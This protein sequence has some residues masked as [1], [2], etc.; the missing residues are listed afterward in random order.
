[1][2]CVLEY[3]KPILSPAQ[4][5]GAEATLDVPQDG[6]LLAAWATRFFGGTP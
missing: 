1:M 3:T 5:A 4:I 6:A 2:R